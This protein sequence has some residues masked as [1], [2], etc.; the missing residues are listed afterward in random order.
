MLAIL[1]L[2]MVM[3]PHVMMKEVL[4]PAGLVCPVK[5][6]RP[7]ELHS[8]AQRDVSSHGWSS[9]SQ[10]HHRSEEYG[11]HS[12]SSEDIGDT[13]VFAGLSVVP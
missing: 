4:T 8:H 5:Q 10:E 13:F 7:G 9:M 3:P 12:S 1:R 6:L 11:I 2:K